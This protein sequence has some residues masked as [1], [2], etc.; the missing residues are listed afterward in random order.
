[1]TQD[2]V[3]EKHMSGRPNIIFIITDQMRGDCLSITGHPVIKTPSLDMLAAQGTVFTRAYAA[4]PSCIAARACM[5]TG[6]TPD[7]VGRIGYSDCVPWDY[8]VTLTS[9]LAAA[10]YQCHCVGKTH[11]YPPVSYTHL[12][13]PTKRIV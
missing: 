10:G 7:S 4:C 9:E 2:G 6:K 12:T 3:K 8:P 11:F 1:M 13:L 5:F